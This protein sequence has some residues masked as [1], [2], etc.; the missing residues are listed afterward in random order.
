MMHIVN[1]LLPPLE[2]KGVPFDEAQSFKRINQAILNLKA[3]TNETL[4]AKTVSLVIRAL[5]THETL[6]YRAD[7]SKEFIYKYFLFC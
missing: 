5:A 3:A 1:Q 4:K 6:K 7:V 2:S